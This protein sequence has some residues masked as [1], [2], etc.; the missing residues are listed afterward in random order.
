MF[1][2]K[3]LC[4]LE[5]YNFLLYCEWKKWE[6]LISSAMFCPN[7]GLHLDL[8]DHALLRSKINFCNLS[9]DSCMI[10]LSC[11]NYMTIFCVIIGKQSWW[12]F[13]FPFERLTHYVPVSS[14]Y[15]NQS[16]DLTGFYM[17]ATLALNGLIKINTKVLMAYLFRL[18]LSRL[19]CSKCHK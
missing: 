17:R 6:W 16:V 18:F 14:L 2:K 11:I 9:H 19:I 4:L 8:Y 5:R 12:R 15:S 7:T 13:Y 3:K 1:D 10:S